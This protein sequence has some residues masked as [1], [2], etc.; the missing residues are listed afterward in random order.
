M[1][2]NPKQVN[3]IIKQSN[4]LNVIKFVPEVEKMTYQNKFK[5]IKLKSKNKEEVK[6]EKP[7]KCMQ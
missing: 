3:R 5:I 7:T 4:K 2:H 6:Q 1:P